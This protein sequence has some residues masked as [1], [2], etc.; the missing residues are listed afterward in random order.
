MAVIQEVE[1][2][3]PTGV[4]PWTYLAVWLLGAAYVLL[5]PALLGSPAWRGEMVPG[6][7]LAGLLLLLFVGVAFRWTSAAGACILLAAW[8]CLEAYGLWGFRD[9]S[10]DAVLIA[11]SSVA[12]IVSAVW[13]IATGRETS[14]RARKGQ[15]VLHRLGALGAAGFATVAGFSYA[16]SFDCGCPERGAIASTQQIVGDW[17]LVARYSAFPSVRKVRFRPDGTGSYAIGNR[18]LDHSPKFRWSIRG[19][20]LQISTPTGC[21]MIYPWTER[22]CARISGDGRTISFSS[23]RVFMSKAMVRL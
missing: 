8:A 5:Q 16:G 17:K 21:T 6:A 20:C 3:R 12:A 22:T 18:T 11:V 23:H 9:S 4:L 14:P 7:A 10:S 19:S 1:E 13:A 2:V 15:W